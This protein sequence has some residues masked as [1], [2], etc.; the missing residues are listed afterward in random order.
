M[1]PGRSSLQPAQA[2]ARSLRQGADGPLRWHDALFGYAVGTPFAWRPV[3]R[4]PRQR[5]TCPSAASSTRRSPGATTAP[6]RPWHE[7]VIYELHVRGFTQAASRGPRRACAAPSPGSQ[8]RSIDYLK[9][10]GVTAVELLPVHAFVDEPHLV[11][12][13]CATTGAT[14]RSASSRPSPLL[15][16]GGPRSS[17]RWSSAALGGIEVI[18]DVVYNHT[19]RGQ[20]PRPDAVASAASTTPPTTGLADDRALLCRLHRLRQHAQPDASARAADGHGFAA[21]LGQEMHVD[22]FRFDLA[23]ALAR[24]PCTASTA[25]RLL[26]RAVARTRCCPRQAD[27]RAL[28]RRPRRLPG[29]Q[30][31][32]RLGRVERPLPRRRARFWRGDGP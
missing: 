7:T 22:G 29:R 2:A 25:G 31:P 8:R 23:T 3:V 19:G 9:R 13:A 20:P 14:T 30:F 24:D 6:D 17:R 11:E 5:P 21:L 18:L 32:A 26:R 4:P 12:R 1:S 28:G 10:L 27:R 16:R 15:R